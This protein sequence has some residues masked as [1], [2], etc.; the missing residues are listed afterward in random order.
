MNQVLTD[1]S[2]ESC[3]KR[4]CSLALSIITHNRDKNKSDLI[5]LDRRLTYICVLRNKQV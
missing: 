2:S 5:N 3:S 1:N 4:G